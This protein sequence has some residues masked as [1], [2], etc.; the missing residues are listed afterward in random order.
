[1]TWVY[2]TVE[3]DLFCGS[4]RN[5]RLGDVAPGVEAEVP[6]GRPL[7]VEPAS[8]VGRVVVVFIDGDESVGACSK[9]GPQGGCGECR[10][11][12]GGR[13]SWFAAYLVAAAYTMLV[14]LARLLPGAVLLGVAVCVSATTSKKYL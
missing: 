10:P 3:M 8:R 5:A 4:F 2:F 14:F 9:G 11:A 13:L 1:M 6:A 12:H 7:A